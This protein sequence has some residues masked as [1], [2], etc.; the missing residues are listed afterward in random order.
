MQYTEHTMT[1]LLSTLPRSPGKASSRTGKVKSS[2]K[3]NKQQQAA[4]PRLFGDAE[5]R[6]ILDNFDL[7]TAERR[8]SLEKQ[9]EAALETLKRQLAN[10]VERIKRSIYPHTLTAS[11][12]IELLE[13]QD[14]RQSQDPGRDAQR[15]GGSDAGLLATGIMAAV[16]EKRLKDAEATIEDDIQRTV[17][18]R[19]R[20]V[21][22]NE[23][24]ENAQSRTSNSPSKPRKVTKIT[25]QAPP[26]PSS[27]AALSS[28]HGNGTTGSMSSRGA[29][30]HN[31][32]MPRS[33]SRS[34]VPR[35]LSSFKAR[36]SQAPSSISNAGNFVYRARPSMNVGSG[37]GPGTAGPPSSSANVFNPRL[38][39]TPQLR[40]GGGN[41]AFPFPGRNTSMAAGTA[42][43]M[44]RRNE[45]I[46]AYSMNGSPLGVLDL[47]IEQPADHDHDRP[48][49]SA[50][51][52]TNGE[53]LD[54]DGGWEMLDSRQ[55]YIPNPA[56][57]QATGSPHKFLRKGTGSQ[58]KSSIFGSRQSQAAQPASSVRPPAQKDFNFVP[59]SSSRVFSS[60]SAASRDS[61]SDGKEQDEDDA[62]VNEF[63]KLSA[64]YKAE[65][66]SLTA[67]M[68][69]NDGD[70]KRLEQSMLSMMLKRDA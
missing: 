58:V 14:Q 44:P 64:K 3:H 7:E 12:Y 66:E 61:G 54:D 45:S 11:Q 47:D 18:K 29:F 36:V 19:K 4:D 60:S 56:A 39:Q 6:L 42:R 9:I 25:A 49:T 67:S 33:V 27:R 23:Q 17:K 20:I 35:G 63:T 69:L 68:S 50:T 65:L 26:T 41:G 31:P 40:Q 2:A 24:D 46:Q 15:P 38:P 51:E 52:A 55:S 34:N 22:L 48:P 43:R 70:R 10:E 59:S 53:T 37:S 57:Q 8:R 32:P 5:A 30:G 21:N 62:H 1:S 16:N 28:A 13:Q